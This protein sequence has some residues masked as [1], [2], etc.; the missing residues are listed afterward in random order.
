MRRRPAPRRLRERGRKAPRDSAGLRRV[1][2]Y[3]PMKSLRPLL[4][5]AALVA[6]P[7]ALT[8]CDLL[9]KK[10]GADASPPAA[11]TAAPV[12]TDTAAPTASALATVTPGAPH[13]HVTP[14][15]LPDGGTVFVSATDGGVAAAT[16]PFAIPS[17][18]PSNFPRTF[19]SG[20]PSAFP[21][22]FPSSLPSG[23]PQFPAPS[24]SAKK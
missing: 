17:T 4:L 12:S 11:E 10:S 14:K 5:L 13:L 7:V 24:A 15:K 8:A 22:G 19:P 20:F 9:K 21:S 6:L 23:F 3:A 16:N 1:V 18:L 2:R